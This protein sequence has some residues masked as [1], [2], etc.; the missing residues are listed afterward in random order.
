MAVWCHAYATTGV[1]WNEQ[2]RRRE[3]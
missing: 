1:N 2:G 3:R